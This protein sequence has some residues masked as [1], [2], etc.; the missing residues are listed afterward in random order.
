MPKSFAELI[1]LREVGPNQYESVSNPEKLGNAANIAYGGCTVAIGIHAAYKTVLSKYHPYSATGY[2]LGPALIDRKLYCSVRSIRDTR[3]FATR[4]VEVSQILDSKQKRSVMVMIVDFQVKE[5][6]MFE[7]SAPP[8]H[9]Y[10]PPEACPTA[11]EWRQTLLESGAAKPEVIKS[12]RIIF[13]L[14]ERMLDQRRCPGGV[15]TENLIGALK[16]V[17]T[18]QDHLPLTE[19]V[20]ADWFR[21]R[22]VLAT[23]AENA[24]ALGFVADGALSFVPLSHNHQ[25]LDDSAACSSLDFAF[26]FFDTSVDMSKWHLREIKTIAGAGGKTYSEARIWDERGKM[27]AI[28]NQLSIMRPH[29]PVKAAL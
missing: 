10:P 23:A 4:Q 14:A 25:F 21:S 1:G 3:T 19:K 29:A 20:S 17:G 18:S 16:H 11:D 9:V 12:N 28:M 5:A 26:R 2:Y 24:A 8:I 15:M 27:V 13:G 7:Y 22:D 6:S